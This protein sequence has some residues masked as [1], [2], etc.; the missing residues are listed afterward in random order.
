M[1]FNLILLK[2][3]ASGLCPINIWFLL[4]VLIQ[5]LMGLYSQESLS[6]RS[7]FPQIQ[8]EK[9]LFGVSFWIWNYMKYLQVLRRPR[10]FGF[11]FC[12]VFLRGRGNFIIRMYTWNQLIVCCHCKNKIMTTP[13]HSKKY[14]KGNTLHPLKRNCS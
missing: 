5:A 4:G 6:F 13:L 8:N 14:S 9:A 1:T 3:F 2:H 10:Y 7:W 12:F 11:L